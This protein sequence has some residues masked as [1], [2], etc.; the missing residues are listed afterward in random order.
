MADTI[1]INKYCCVVHINFVESIMFKL[2]VIQGNIIRQAAPI[3]HG[4]SLYLFATVLNITTDFLFELFR[5]IV[6]LLFV[7]PVFILLC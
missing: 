7:V 6:V 2:R 3:I 4:F 5:R 1:L